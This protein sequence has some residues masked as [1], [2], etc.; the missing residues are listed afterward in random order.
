MLQKHVERDDQPMSDTPDNGKIQE[1]P[2][3]TEGQAT[4]TTPID[5]Q[6]TTQPL[7]DSTP[8]PSITEAPKIEKRPL[9]VKTKETK[10]GKTGKKAQKPRMRDTLT[11]K[12]SLFVNY[13]TD[14][15]SDTY[16]NKTRSYLKAYG[17]NSYSA[18]SSS[19]IATLEKPRIKTWIDEILDKQ[20]A[21]VEARVADV[22]AIARGKCKRRIVTKQA[23]NHKTGEI[24]TLTNEYEPS[25]SEQLEAHKLL[26]KIA[27]DTDTSKHANRLAEQEHREVLKH[28]FKVSK[29]KQQASETE[30]DVTPEGTE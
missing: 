15:N 21:G 5:N 22:L 18:A 20:N 2:Q 6:A 27:G 16:G 30:R 1:Q 8:C 7:S 10:K 25:H 28:V 29:V 9:G 24:V 11:L 3:N 4:D 12:Q 19:A 17:N 23:V 26:A 13:Y 14:P